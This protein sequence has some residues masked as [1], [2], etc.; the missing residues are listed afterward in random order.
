MSK[1]VSR[2]CPG[3]K[4]EDPINLLPEDYCGKDGHFK[5][6]LMDDYEIEADEVIKTTTENNEQLTSPHIEEQKEVIYS[7]AYLS[8]SLSK[9][10]SETETLEPES[11]Y[12]VQVKR[13]NTM[14]VTYR[15]KSR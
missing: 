8:I 2:N 4:L 15:S 9:N 5:S 11:P 1:T 12:P 7:N 14:P 10:Q 3:I 13:A 6:A